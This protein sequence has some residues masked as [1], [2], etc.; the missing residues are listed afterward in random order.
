MSI[1]QP[2]MEDMK[3]RRFACFPAAILVFLVNAAERVLFLS[4][5]QQNDHWEIVKGAIEA[6]ETIEEAAYRETKEEVGI[7]VQVEPL[8][9]IHASTVY[10]DEKV[11]YALGLYYLMAY[12]GGKVQ[13][14]DDMAGSRC[15]WWSWGEIV[16]GKMHIGVPSEMWVI[17]RAIEL[18]RLW[19]R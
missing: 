4:H 6:G 5:P 2:I 10:H 18:Y 15:Q 1:S 11:P 9:I 7:K 13:P 3:G 8:G 19:K 16:E 14:G 12:R 17:K